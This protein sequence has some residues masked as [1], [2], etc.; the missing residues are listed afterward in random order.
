MHG[1]AQ[2]AVAVQRV[3]MHGLQ[4]GKLKALIAVRTPRVR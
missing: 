4:R 2:H 1:F 3:G